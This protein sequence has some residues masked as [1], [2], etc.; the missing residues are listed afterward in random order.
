M[1][2][3]LLKG[4]MESTCSTESAVIDLQLTAGPQH[5]L[6]AGNKRTLLP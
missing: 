1:S 5:L 2:L 4:L 3:L 6:R